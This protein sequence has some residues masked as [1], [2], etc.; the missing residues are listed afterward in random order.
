M[1]AARIVEAPRFAVTK[2]D[3]LFLDTFGHGAGNEFSVF[4]N[5]RDL[6]M[7]RRGDLKPRLFMMINWRQLVNATQGT[8]E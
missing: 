7:V 3:T 2:Q 4:P 5:G 1:I 8:R 6:L